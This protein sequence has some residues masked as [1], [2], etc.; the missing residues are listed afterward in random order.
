M[1][2]FILYFNVIVSASVLTSLLGYHAIKDYEV[3]RCQDSNRDKIVVVGV[4]GN[5]LTE[6]KQG[7]MI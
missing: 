6:C 1:D 2:R 7:G 3:G 4:Y 5:Q